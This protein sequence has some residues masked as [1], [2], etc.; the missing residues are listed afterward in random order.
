IPAFQ[1]VN[2]AA[3]RDQM[4]DF[5]HP[6]AQDQRVLF[7]LEDPKG[8][9]ERIYDGYKVLLHLAFYTANVQR[10]HLMPDYWAVFQTNYE[11]APNLWGREPEAVEANLERWQADFA[12]VYQE[13]SRELDPV[14][15]SRGFRPVTRFD[16]QD[17]SDLGFHFEQREAPVWWLLQKPDNLPAQP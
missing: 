11:G 3:M 13:A 4:T 9:Y 7:A 14:W 8:V 2:I 10:I 15:E 6:V 17:Y 1:P 12:I 16:W 5:L